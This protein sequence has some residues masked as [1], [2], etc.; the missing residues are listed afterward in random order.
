MRE[1]LAVME[2]GSLGDAARRLKVR[3]PNLT[4]S[5]QAL[6][7]SLGNSLFTR[8]PQGMKPTAL[9]FAL[10][11]RAKVIAG[12]VGRAQREIGEFL[13]AQRGR[14]VI[15]TGPLFSHPAF[16][17]AVA[18]FRQAHPKVD[19]TIIH[20]QTRE[21]FP[22]VKTGDVDFCLHV[23]SPGSFDP[24]LAHEIIMRGQKI[25]VATSSA[26]PLAKKRRVSLREVAA[27]RWMLPIA[28]DSLRARVQEVVEAKGLP[29][30]HPALECDS[31]LMLKSLLRN[32]DLLGIFIDLV[33]EDE[34]KAKKVKFLNVP[35]L[36]WKIDLSAIYRRG[37][38]LPPAAQMLLA[39]I[40]KTCA[41]QQ[42]RR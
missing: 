31:V 11:Q 39:E 29:P 16:G 21:I 26:N 14:V 17:Q 22:A 28:P 3:Q 8:S 19:V 24:E 12:E 38:P 30:I 41:E 23:V 34:L 37:I 2:A 18:R 4:K 36:T 10:E 40:R 27:A 32:R 7:R 6:E 5:I 13:E 42:R 33:I 35:E 15:G 25:S 1:F 20:R 9:A